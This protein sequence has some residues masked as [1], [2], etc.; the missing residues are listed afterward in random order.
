MQL[1]CITFATIYDC[2]NLIRNARFRDSAAL[3]QSDYD[4][5]NAWMSVEVTHKKKKNGMKNWIS[6]QEVD[7][8]FDLLLEKRNIRIYKMALS[9]FMAFYVQNKID[10]NSCSERIQHQRRQ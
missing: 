9:S 10:R 6:L 7:S 5:R 3:W 1:I 8:V 2:C 4:L